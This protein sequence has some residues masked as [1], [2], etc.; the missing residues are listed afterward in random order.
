MLKPTTIHLVFKDTPL[1]EAVAEFHKKAGYPIVVHDP[2]NKLKD[3]T[4]TLDTGDTT[5]WKALDLFCEKAGVHEA[6]QQELVVQPILPPNGVVPP[7]IN[8]IVPIP[9]QPNRPLENKSSEK[10]TGFAA[11]EPAARPAAPPVAAPP[12]AAPGVLIRPIQPRLPL[13]SG[14]ITLIDGKPETQP[15]DYSSAVRVR[16]DECREL[17][18]QRGRRN[19]S[20]RPAS[21]ART[22]NHLAKPGGRE[23]REGRLT[24][25]T[26]NLPKRWRRTVLA[27]SSPFRSEAAVSVPR[28]PLRA[29]RFG[30]AGSW[31]T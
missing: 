2:E 27:V 13:Q 30:M 12:V 10:P 8:P 19:H 25:R 18:R 16:S 23:D 24:T 3:R 17:L 5:F 21:H 22:E 7:R 28:S 29:R 1:N 4:I 9:R 31:A 15:T 11:E 14:Q 20:A 26:S 6:T